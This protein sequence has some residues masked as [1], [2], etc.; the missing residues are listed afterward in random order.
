MCSSVGYLH[1]LRVVLRSACVFSFRMT[2][3][4][5]Q[6]KRVWSDVGGV[7]PKHVLPKRLAHGARVVQAVS[8][9]AK[10]VTLLARKV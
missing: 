1:S 5:K 2:Q 7:L 8:Q 4:A 3:G 10:R 6:L 9:T